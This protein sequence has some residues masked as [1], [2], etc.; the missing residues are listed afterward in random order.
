MVLVSLSAAARTEYQQTGKLWVTAVV[1]AADALGNAARKQ[2]SISWS[3][4]GLETIRKLSRPIQ[5]A[6]TA[7]TRSARRRAG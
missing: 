6:V 1:D 5:A 2:R 4:E 3:A 7:A